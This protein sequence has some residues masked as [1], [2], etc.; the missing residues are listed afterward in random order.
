VG[1]SPTTRKRRMIH[2]EKNLFDDSLRGP[3]DYVF[4]SGDHNEPYTNQENHRHSCV[5][6]PSA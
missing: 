1:E 5:L 4:Y 2:S 6:H 3:L